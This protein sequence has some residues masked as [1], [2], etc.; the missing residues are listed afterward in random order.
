MY[1]PA[2]GR[3]VARQGVDT[4]SSDGVEGL[5]WL[6]WVTYVNCRKLRDYWGAKTAV[7]H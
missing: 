4:P 2:T 6:V 5:G 7:R 3:P 1:S